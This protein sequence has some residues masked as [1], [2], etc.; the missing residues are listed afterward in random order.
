LVAHSWG[1][2]AAGLFASR[3]PDLIDRLVF[4][5]PL[6]RCDGPSAP[7]P[8]ILDVM[9]SQCTLAAPFKSEATTACKSVVGAMMTRAYG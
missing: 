4:F 6:T 5:G 8:P 2:I 9:V 3:C 7:V 1:T